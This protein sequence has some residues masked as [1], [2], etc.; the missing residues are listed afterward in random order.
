M[1]WSFSYTINHGI[2]FENQSKEILRK[3]LS[4]N[5]TYF[6]SAAT[7]S[8][9][10]TVGIV[11]YNSTNRHLSDTETRHMYLMISCITGTQKEKLSPITVTGFLKTVIVHLFL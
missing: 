8:F 5:I 4:L 6:S 10:C 1:K 3:E 7:C 2:H 11:F 9:L